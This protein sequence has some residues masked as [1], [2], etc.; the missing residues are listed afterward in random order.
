[1]RNTKTE[2]ENTL[3]GINNRIE[4]SEEWVSDPKHKVMES[5]QV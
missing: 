4:E 1:M 2:I 3:E 5:N